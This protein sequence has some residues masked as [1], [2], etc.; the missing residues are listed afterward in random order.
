MQAFLLDDEGKI[1]GYILHVRRR[2]LND[3]VEY[4]TPGNGDFQVVGKARLVEKKD[5]IDQIRGKDLKEYYIRP[6]DM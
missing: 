2:R 6:H 3:I 1:V 5:Y 4:G